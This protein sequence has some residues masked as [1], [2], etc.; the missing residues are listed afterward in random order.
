MLILISIGLAIIIHLSLRYTDIYHLLPNS[1]YKII[2]SYPR[3][4]FQEKANLSDIA[5][6]AYNF[7]GNFNE[8]ILFFGIIGQ[9]YSLFFKEYFPDNTFQLCFSSFFI[10][11]SLSSIPNA[12]RFIYHSF[13]LSFPFLISFS[14]DYLKK[15]IKKRTFIK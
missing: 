13:L 6:N 12:D 5:G 9:I 1:Q 7:Y 8:K 10:C 15:V 14:I 2:L 4:V 3:I 11:A